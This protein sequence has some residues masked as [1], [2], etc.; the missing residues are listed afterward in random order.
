M[1]TDWFLTVQLDMCYV[2][3][4]NVTSSIARS[5]DKKQATDVW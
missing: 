4:D 5:G 1:Q 2:M 3:M